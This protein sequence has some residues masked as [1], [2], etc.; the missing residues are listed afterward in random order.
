MY[1]LYISVYS[2]KMVGKLCAIYGGRTI[3]ASKPKHSKGFGT[4]CQ[5]YL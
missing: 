1:Q 3:V 4:D 5:I 2:G